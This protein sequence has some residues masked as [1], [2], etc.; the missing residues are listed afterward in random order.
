MRIA[1]TLCIFLLI[2]VGM[3]VLQIVLSRSKSR[4]LGLILPIC[5]FLFS[6]V[7]PLNMMVT[8]DSLIS[9]ILQMLLIWVLANI[10]T[11]ILLAIYFACRSKHRRKKQ[12]DKMNIQDLG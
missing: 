4:W 8:D 12:F 10:P 5:S 2:T 1:T 9:L 6:L 11:M 3:V 7:Y